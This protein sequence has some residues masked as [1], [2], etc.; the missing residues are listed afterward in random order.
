L[1][2]HRLPVIATVDSLTGP[3]RIY[4]ARFDSRADADT[5]RTKLDSLGY[6]PAELFYIGVAPKMT[7]TLSME[8]EHLD[9]S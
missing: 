6:D 9:V 1:F 8:I 5:M 4:A 7:S 2:S 3:A